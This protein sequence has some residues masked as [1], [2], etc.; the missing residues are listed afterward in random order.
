M[1]TATLRGMLAHKLRLVLTTASIALGVAFL[2][3][4]L[5]LTDTMGLAF[6][7]LF[8]KVSAG[9][10]A[11]VRTEAAYTAS[12]GVGTSRG[13]IA[14]SVLDQV[15]KVDG[16][17]A[18]EGSVTGYALLTD[19]DGKA[20]LTSGGA[21]TMGYSMPADEALRGDVELLTGT[22]PDGPHEVA[23]DATSA[24]EHHI[25]LGSHDQGPVPRSDPGVHRRR[26][27]RLRRREEPRRH[28]VGVLRHRD[29]A[30]GARARPA[31]STRSTCSADRR[32]HARPSWPSGST[33]SLPEGAEAVTGA[34]V[35]KESVRR[36]QQGPQVRRAS[37][38]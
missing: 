30:A 6:D 19:N 29:R 38:S 15:R 1:F 35:A 8:G 23:I 11:V 34:T 18:A 17:R 25:A 33:R 37:C 27:R 26:H 10:D 13:P 21:P 5:I 4:T 28:H 3:G 24:E 9:T 32:R 31:C 14:A 20:I 36:D 12:E 2:A 7:Q 22:R 16:V